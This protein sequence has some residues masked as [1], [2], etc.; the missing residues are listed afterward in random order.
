MKTLASSLLAFSALF[1]FQVDAESSVPLGAPKKAAG[2]K[3]DMFGCLQSNDYY[4]A[5][6]AAYQIDLQKLK[7]TK[8]LPEAECVDLPQTGPTQ[9]SVDMLD[10]DVRHKEVSLRVVRGDGQVIAESPP[11]LA[12]QGVLTV[13]VDF[14]SPGKYEVRVLVK[15]RDLNIP[16]ETSALLIPLSVALPPDIPAPKGGLAVFFLSIGALAGGV[17]W[18]LPR[19]LKPQPAA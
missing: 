6:F 7:E 12:K 13:Q 19:L 8:R 16:P 3:R 11:T 5:N 4:V 17:A 15:D 1:L 10:R 18:L 14:K 9:I 2:G